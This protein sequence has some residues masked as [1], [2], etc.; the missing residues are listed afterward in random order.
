ME[1]RKCEICGKPTAEADFSKSYKNRCKPCV[2]E[3]TRERRTEQKEQ[4]ED[5]TTS[6]EPR[7]PNIV[8]IP[9][10]ESRLF[11]L[12]KAALQGLLASPVWMQLQMQ[13]TKEACKGK[14]LEEHAEYLKKEIAEDATEIARATLAQL[15]QIELG[16]G[17]AQ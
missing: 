15:E 12:T 13:N 11:E 6:I 7:W 1:L 5:A 17:D 3:L 9:V 2:A 14:T 16:K 4:P 10:K 8:Q